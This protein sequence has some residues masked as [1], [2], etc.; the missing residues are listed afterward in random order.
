MMN[1]QAEAIHDIAPDA[2]G[3]RILLLM[4]PGAKNTPQQLVDNGFIRE[5]R[6]RGLPVDVL[7]LHAHVDHYL[8]RA[9][10]EGLLHHTLDQ[11]RASGYRRIWLLGISL[12]GSGAMICATQRAS[13]IEG[14]LLLAPFLG[15]RGL[16]A[17]VEA[18]GGLHCWQAGEIGSR[19]YER[20]LL[21]QIRRSPLA[22]AEFPV[23][24]LG[25]GSEDRFRGASMMLSA[26]LPPHHVTVMSG[27]HDWDTWL[28]LWQNL[29]NKQPFIR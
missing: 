17:E 12:G 24:Y 26:H 8:N 20:A 11:V 15:T 3:E 10:I 27:G 13:E 23:L 14:V 18:A 2:A 5:L 29:L 25:Y 28:V 21:E 1:L 4:L 7:A 22:T 9:D 16:I 6:E 19:D